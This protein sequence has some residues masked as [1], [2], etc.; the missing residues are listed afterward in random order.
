MKKKKWP[1]GIKSKRSLSEIFPFLSE[2]TRKLMSGMT[3][4]E[5]RFEEDKRRWRRKIIKGSHLWQER[6]VC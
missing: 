6:R 4:H 3:K 2:I 5:K 1:S